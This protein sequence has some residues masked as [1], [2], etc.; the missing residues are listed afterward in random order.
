M[1]SDEVKRKLMIKAGLVHKVF[2]SPDG[3]QVFEFLK[4]QFDSGELFS[5]DNPNLTNYRLGARDVVVYI[6]QLINHKEKTQ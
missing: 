1:I 2:S 3:K 5:P 4:E 6:Q